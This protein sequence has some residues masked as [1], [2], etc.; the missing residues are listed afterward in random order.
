M[1]TVESRL[2]NPFP[3]LRPF[4]S[5]EHHLFFGRE[6]QTAALLQL[7][8]TN[9]F[10]AV[11]GTS[12]SGKSSLVRAGMIAELHGGTMTQAGSSW[13]VMVLRP[14]G[15]PIENLARAVVDA[16]LYDRED[17][18]TLPR[19]LATLSRSRFG[20]VEATKQSDLFEPGTKLL[21]V[22]DQFEELFRFRQQGVDSEETAASFVNLLLTA[23]E[24]SESPIYVTITMRSDYLGDCS[25]IPGLAEA[26][27]RG[28]YL[29]PR[30]LRDQKRDAIEKPI[31]VGSAKI[32]PLLVQRLLN[33]VGDDPDQLPVLQHALMR[34]W[35]AWSTSGDPDRPIETSDFEATGG[36]ASAL[37]NHADEI[38]DSL[39]DDHHRSACE[40]I[41]KTLTEKGS[42]NRGIRRPTRLAQLAAIAD[43]DNGT[44]T[45]VLDAFRGHGVT[46][47]MP[48]PDVDLDDRTVL[49]LSH[50][51]LMRGWE[52]LRGWV[53]DEAQSAR[54]FR[55][56]LDTARLW[57][58]GKAGLFRDPDLQIALSWREQESPNSEWSEQYGGHFETAIAFLERSNAEAEA[59]RQA[60]EAARQRELEQARELAEAQRLRLDQQQ[61]SARRLRK[62]IG[63]L[64]VVAV[65]AG[66]ACVA[67]LFAN[68]RANQSAQQA[69]QSEQEA[70]QARTAAEKS[71][72]AAQGEAYRAVFS[73]ARALR[74][75]HEPGWRDEA[76][77]DLARLATS[78]SPKRNLI[79]LRTEAVAA[80]SVPDVRLIAQ[81]EPAIGFNSFAFG[82]DGQTLATSSFGRL[83]FW[84]LKELKHVAAAEGLGAAQPAGTWDGNKVIFLSGQGG[85]A[86][87]THDQGVVFT[88]LAGT[89][90]SRS[91]IT[92]GTHA[93]FALA[94]DSA[95]G[96]LAVRWA[97]GAG[98]TVHD[99]TSGEIL[100]EFPESPCALSPDGQW[101]ASEGPQ[102]EV[103][104]HRIGSKE[105]GK[106]LGRHTGKIVKFAFS[107]D[108]NTL[109]S[110]SWD[111]T[112]T[113]WDVAGARQPVV[114]RGH[115]ETIND[116]A[117][118]P[119]GRWVATAST[120]FTARIWDVLTG[121]SV[122]T[123]PGPW[124]MVGVLWSPDGAFLAV[125]ADTRWVYLYRIAGRRIFQRLA[126]HQ[127]GV[128][129]VAA[130]PRLDRF[131]TGADD[132]L[133][134][135][136]DLATAQPSR[137][138]IGTHPGWVTAVAYSPDGSLLATGA[139][140][141]ILV[142]R[143]AETGDIK[144]R[145]TGQKNEIHSLA[146]DPSGRRLAGGYRNG[147]VVVWDL[148]T[149][150]PVQQFQV[151]PSYVWSIAF[152][153]EGRKL[154]SEVSNGR[155]VL[156][157]IESAKEEA[158]ITLPGR[159]RRFIADPARKRLI[160]AFS[161]GDLCS[162]SIPD[163]TP[164]HRLEHAHPSAIESLALSPDGRL[165]AT[166][167]A[168]RRVVFRD[169]VT[170]EPLLALPEW[171]AMVKDVAFTLAGRRLAYVGADSDIAL[172]DL[173]ALHQGLEAS[174]LAWDQPAPAVVAATP[175]T[176]VAEQLRPVVPIIRDLSAVIDPAAFEQ[177]RRLVQSGIAAF[178]GGRRAEAIRD[179]KL[180]RDGLRGLYKASHGNGQI[181]S[182]LAISY[183]S[184]GSALRDEHR[185]AEA[186]A[187]I[188]EARQVLEAISQPSF[189]DLYNLAC[190]YANLS[191]LVQPGL[192]GSTVAERQALTNQ[193]MAALR[194]SLA[195][196]MADFD[197]IDRDHD[198]DP[199]RERSDFRALILQSTGHT[200]EAVPHLATLS[201]ANPT[202]TTLSIKVASLQAWFG[203]E[204][205]LAAT[206]QR[207]LA[208]AKGTSDENAIDRAAKA[209]C[210]LP[211]TDKAEVEA[212]LALARKA[213][214]IGKGSEWHLLALGMAE[215]R[216]GND[217]AADEALLA[218]A[219]AGPEN[220][221][222]TSISAFYRAMSLFRQNKPEEARKLATATA[223]QMKPLP[224]DE[225]N[226]LADNAY[227]DDLI[228]WL[229]WKEART[230]L[231]LEADLAEPPKK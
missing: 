36:L 176:P 226:P 111:Q 26:V 153:D 58:D 60:K 160:V 124:F 210:I 211:S 67:A 13:E 162:L 94:A 108:G 84:N 109:G 22:V 48:G 74:A 40:K 146:F 10:L 130:H 200:R 37:S 188:K 189:M 187:S 114:L 80:L 47:L 100:G 204:S 141:G 39:P 222:A 5:D 46:F 19:L 177:A 186:M 212:A 230:L 88:D 76:L 63:G 158:K 16:E 107:A 43:S 132:H 185:S 21:V 181:A 51:S 33:D 218:A 207:I 11:V 231:K 225:Q 150:K 99:L 229:A 57:S 159:V 27:N 75:G 123:L 175:P 42:D 228:L 86:V 180:A 149:Q 30:L 4:S 129:C 144:A 197:L 136:W 97:D 167:G 15:S 156:F 223:A 168:D 178:E 154:V 41:F 98:I 120:D 93:A 23:S 213:V 215:Y 62:M 9:R 174:G 115:R 161:N 96:R 121:Q 202:D 217:A 172:W 195:A 87:A 145:L 14:G 221:Y 69:K 38:Y 102:F 104:L 90:A 164:G 81:L 7:L 35:E 117:F 208:F 209:C 122:A 135:E 105:P 34:M 147:R 49:D 169:P 170:F 110:T 101:L 163:L 78:P 106:S 64:A 32:S 18:A 92:R 77:A 20:L 227:H 95:S 203:Q 192:A 55:R 143:D 196:G 198:V 44:V 166:G 3:G 66:L 28:E 216:A 224:A 61:R 148:A 165:L 53:E 140:D 126:M 70:D 91:P 24:Q 134:I 184:L 125:R 199:L 12:G 206:R 29:I 1:N 2:P 182:L 25:E 201:A 65:I 113:L 190:A 220:P 179:L 31:G 157:D 191:A 131:A 72:E 139:G 119:D 103:L 128:Q 52:R 50:E 133:V 56:L 183:G 17:P 73:E 173:T 151:G 118:S 219:K 127:H 79:E 45:K 59:E 193:A 205:E 8:R 68:Q 155:V 112:A 71:R 137:R 138:W 85:L 142:V 194:R 152:L 82:P 116:L 54:I 171:T 214:E 6:E 89:R 83:D